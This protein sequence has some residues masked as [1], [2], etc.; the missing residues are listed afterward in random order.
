MADEM[1]QM[2]HHTK[3]AKMP[4]PSSELLIKEAKIPAHYLQSQRGKS[5]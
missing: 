5:H 1:Q 4:V 3:A 2:R